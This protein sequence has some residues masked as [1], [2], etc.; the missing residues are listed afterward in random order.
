MAC[1]TLRTSRSSSSCR[2][3]SQGRD[4]QRTLAAFSAEAARA[5]ARRRD[6]ARLVCSIRAAAVEMEMVIATALGDGPR[7]SVSVTHRPSGLENAATAMAV[8]AAAAAK[9]QMRANRTS[10]SCQRALE[11]DRTSSGW[12]RSR[13][14]ASPSMCSGK[15]SIW[16]AYSS[17]RESLTALAELSE[18]AIVALLPMQG[19]RVGVYAHDSWF[20]DPCADIASCDST[21][22]DN[23]APEASTTCE[24]VARSRVRSTWRSVLK[25][26]LD[27]PADCQSDLAREASA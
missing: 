18:E 21:V 2:R 19:H 4:S 23:K 17:L 10:K 16:L 25:S 5:W 11:S 7:P 22:V 8:P 3:S 24:I 14:Y 13:M 20:C 27:S 9:E 6:S 12:T 26:V 15:S 1:S